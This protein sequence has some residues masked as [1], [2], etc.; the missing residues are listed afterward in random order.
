[1]RR[2]VAPADAPRRT[3]T[4]GVQRGTGGVLGVRTWLLSKSALFI[5]AVQVGGKLAVGQETS[6]CRDATAATFGA[7]SSGNLIHARVPK[8]GGG[9]E[10]L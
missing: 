10:H 2:L 8:R 1:M 3:P 5:L 4:P 6:E 7:D 9:D